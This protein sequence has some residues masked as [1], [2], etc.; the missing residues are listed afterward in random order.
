MLEPGLASLGPRGRVLDRSPHPGQGSGAGGSAESPGVGGRGWH[1]EDW[2]GGPGLASA[3]QDFEPENC[4][5]SAAAERN[6]DEG[7]DTP[8]LPADDLTGMHGSDC[9]SSFFVLWVSNLIELKHES[10]A[11]EIRQESENN[12]MSSDTVA[13]KSS[14]DT[15]TALTKQEHM[16]ECVRPELAS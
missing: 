5:L 7:S 13:S 10:V 12:N 4:T 8:G 16:L 14:F 15:T 3:P 11:W 6:R 2:G 1:D 9:L